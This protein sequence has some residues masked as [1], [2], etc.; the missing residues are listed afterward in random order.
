[1]HGGPRATERARMQNDNFGVVSVLDDDDRFSELPRLA[2]VD[3]AGASVALPDFSSGATWDA[4]TGTA[5]AELPRMD[6]AHVSNQVRRAVPGWPRTAACSLLLQR[7]MCA[8][9]C[10]G[11]LCSVLHVRSRAAGRP[12]P[13]VRLVAEGH[14]MRMVLHACRQFWLPAH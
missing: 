13:A 6:A 3:S 14:G 11:F 5:S 10:R 7:R 8:L 1:M 4:C 2:L 9:A 12:T